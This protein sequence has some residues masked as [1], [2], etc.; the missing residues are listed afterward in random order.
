M[1]YIVGVAILILLLRAFNL[2]PK[3]SNKL[4]GYIDSIIV[5]AASLILLSRL[6][7]FIAGVILTLGIIYAYRKGFFNKSE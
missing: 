3:F 2:V 7:P 5:G 1:Y 6:P 4:W